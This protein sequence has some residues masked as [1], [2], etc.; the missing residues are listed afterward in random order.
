[1]SFKKSILVAVD[2]T[3]DSQP[4]L[5]L[6]AN[7]VAL[8]AGKI[9]PEVHLLVGIDP[10]ARD[11]SAINDNV[12]RERSYFENLI[13]KLQSVGVDT[14]VKVSWSKDWADSLIYTAQQ[15][16]AD[17]IMVSNP[18]ASSTRDFSDEFWY[19]LRNAPVP[20]GLIT[21]PEATSI[22]N[23]L[24]AM[25]VRDESISELNGRMLQ[26][27]RS[28]ADLYGGEMHL[29]HAYANSMEYPDRGRMVKALNIPN[30]NIHLAQGDVEDALRTIVQEVQPGAVVLGATRRTGIRAALRGR[31]LA[32]IFRKVD[33]NI[34][35]VV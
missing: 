24:V 3:R 4:A 34:Y 17:M 7:V 16:E 23:V 15:V 18:G 27:G 28:L 20:V 35:M 29:A 32:E 25:D 22:K 21:N 11:T 19:L 30:E 1:M 10:G 14:K 5:D 6:T 26:I 8:N 31:K 9:K 12:Y 33:H 2:P 13:I